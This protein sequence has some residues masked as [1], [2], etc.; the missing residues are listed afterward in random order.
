MVGA[1]FVIILAS[2]AFTNYLV[3]AE[4]P[5]MLVGWTTEHVESKLVFLLALNLLLLLVGM[6]M[7]IFSAIVI[8]LP[9]IAPIAKVYG[10]DPYHLGVIFLLNLEVGYLTP[11]VGLNL[12]I[13]SIKFQVP[14]IDVMRSTLP[15]LLTLIVALGIVTYVPALTIV[16]EAERTSPLNVLQAIVGDGIREGKVSIATLTLVDATGAELK[17]AKGQPIVRSYKDCAGITD[18]TARTVCETLFDN[19]TTCRPDA[20]STDPKQIDCMHKAI[21]AW[22]V[23]NLNGDLNDL[24]KAVITVKEV[25]LIDGEGN[26]IK[27]DKGA[28]IVK[29]HAACDKLTGTERETCLALFI[30]ASSCQIKDHDVAECVTEKTQDC[31]PDGVA[32]CTAERT[33][34][35]RKDAADA[36]IKEKAA[37]WAE[38][39]PDEAKVE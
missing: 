11:P 35:C 13:T 1:I 33:A 39:Y 19:V 30:E 24:E 6:I 15:F 8:V 31:P 23:S 37:E 14:V 2:T 5:K 29:K 21:A 22:V 38:E 20:K 3:T 4:V 36:C 16:P 7:D 26:A 28:P 12:F 10:I 17:D 9:L 25:A 18:E 32:S 27:T 34:A